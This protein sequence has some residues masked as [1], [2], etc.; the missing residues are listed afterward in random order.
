[1]VKLRSVKTS[2]KFAG[3]VRSACFVETFRFPGLKLYALAG[4][5]TDREVLSAP[6][7]A[8][9]GAMRSEERL[10]PYKR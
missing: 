1:M 10:M 6:K 7:K 9:L 3:K 5:A 4:N 2:S 8:C